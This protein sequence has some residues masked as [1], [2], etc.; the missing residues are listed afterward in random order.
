MKEWLKERRQHGASLLDIKPVNCGEPLLP[1]DRS[2]LADDM[3][4]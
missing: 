1:F 4:R 3:F 2:E